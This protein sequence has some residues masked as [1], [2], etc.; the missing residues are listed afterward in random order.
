MALDEFR[1]VE[2]DLDSANDYVPPVVLST[3]DS[4]GRVLRVSL[5]DGGK[6][7]SASGLTARLAYNAA[8]GL[9]ASP[10]GYVAAAAVAGAP[11]ATFDVAVPASKLKAGEASLALEVT[12]SSG[13]VSTRTFRA[14]VERSPTDSASASPDLYRDLISTIA[15]AKTATSGANVAAKTANDAA[16]NANRAASAADNA[17][18]NANRAAS[19]ANGAAGDATAAAQNALNIAN[20]IA[21]SRPS[22]GS[23][24][25]ELRQANA[26]LAAAIAELRD[27]YVIVVESLYVPASRVAAQSG[28]SLALSKSTVSGETATLS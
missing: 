14:L 6:P 5:T 3:G 7:V 16:A 22:S 23:E 27:S 24:I 9:S 4:G 25:E 10:G 11:T 20:S 18:A 8:P 13:T 12:D 26:V 2:V 19:A 1:R 28:E 21:A 17:A 15:A